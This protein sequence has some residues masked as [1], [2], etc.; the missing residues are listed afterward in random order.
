M[1]GTP[2]GWQGPASTDDSSALIHAAVDRLVAAVERQRV[3]LA[4]TVGL[5][6]TDLPA[7]HHVS[8]RDD[9]TPT[10]LA[11]MLMLSSGG[12]TAAIDRLER[13][14]L[15]TRSP[16]PSGRRRVFV[17]V[18]PEGRSLSTGSRA[19]LAA[20]VAQLSVMLPSAERAGIEGFLVRLADLVERHT[21]RLIDDAE[22][23]AETAAGIPSPLLWA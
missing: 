8:R 16:G 7:L 6:R 9:M 13:A 2:S 18:T 10:E 15:V 19:P 21:D 20:D 5:L 17:R 22:E 4:R 1:N 3:A 23:A 12:T 14:R 11:E